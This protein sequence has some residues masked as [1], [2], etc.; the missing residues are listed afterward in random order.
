MRQ[1]TNGFAKGGLRDITGNHEEAGL[2]QQVLSCNENPRPQ[3]QTG[4]KAMTA[5][6]KE[7]G[8]RVPGSECDARKTLEY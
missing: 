8:G 4:E 6:L 2:K 7:E 5:C 3:E 1:L